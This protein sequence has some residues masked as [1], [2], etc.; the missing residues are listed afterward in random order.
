MKEDIYALLNDLNVDVP[1]ETVSCSPEEL[2]KIKENMQG[3]IKMKNTG[4]KFRSKI[5]VA[6]ALVLVGLALTPPGK[7]I[8]GHM[9]SLYEKMA[10]P[11][12]TYA[13]DG[14]NVERAITNVQQSKV[15]EG[16]KVSIENV[17]L[18]DNTLLIN[19]F[20]E[21]TKDYKDFQEGTSYGVGPAEM[22]LYVNGEKVEGSRGTIQSTF[23]NPTTVQEYF[24]FTPTDA[25]FQDGDELQM[26]FTEMQ[27]FSLK[28]LPM[29]Q[30]EKWNEKT[31]EKAVGKVD[32]SWPISCHMKD[33]TKHLEE[34]TVQLSNQTLTY[35]EGTVTVTRFALSPYRSI[36]HVHF[37]PKDRWLAQQLL[38]IGKDDKGHEYRFKTGIPP[39]SIYQEYGVYQYVKEPSEELLAQ[40]EL[41]LQAYFQ[42][43]PDSEKREIIPLGKE[44][45]VSIK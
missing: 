31:V 22:D 17:L 36:I 18:D 25:K 11:I 23:V 1:E 26:A 10:H 5:A 9:V 24:F 34:E 19:A 15:N 29:D 45:K 42:K 30:V 44:W 28:D 12:A 33:G 7:S 3:R 2:R 8:Y 38:F 4:K 39:A 40:K 14:K 21:V 32:G 13:I 43:S 16:I 27:V 41:T 35:Q 20:Y 37:D 6:A